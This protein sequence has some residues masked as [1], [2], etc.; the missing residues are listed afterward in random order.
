M[1]WENLGILL[2][3]YPAKKGQSR[4]DFRAPAHITQYTRQNSETKPYTMGKL[5]PWAGATS[6]QPAEPLNAAVD[7]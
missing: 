1:Q 3:L 5:L 6:A 2:V 7:F 4:S